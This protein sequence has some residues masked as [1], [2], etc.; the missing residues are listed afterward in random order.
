MSY[1]DYIKNNIDDCFYVV[2]HYGC[3]STPSDLWTP[4]TNLFKNFNDAY[5]YFLKV[6]PDLNNKDN[7]AEQSIPKF[8]SSKINEK[9]AV[10]EVRVQTAGYPYYNKEDDVSYAK[11]PEGVVLARCLL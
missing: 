3:N 4:Q 8:D 2:T 9:Y 7:Y 10:I 6:S 5:E 11:R 1:H